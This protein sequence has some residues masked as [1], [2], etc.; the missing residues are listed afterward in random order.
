MVAVWKLD[1]EEDVVGMVEAA[2]A[3]IQLIPEHLYVPYQEWLEVCDA[4]DEARLQIEEDNQGWVIEDLEG[5]IQYLH[6]VQA[7][8]EQDA[9]DL[10]FRFDE[11]EEEL[12]EQ[13]EIAAEWEKKHAELEAYYNP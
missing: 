5:Q 13:R 1:I 12:A 3:D 11:I 9:R 7:E 8:L 6:E 10:Q 2:K 4:L